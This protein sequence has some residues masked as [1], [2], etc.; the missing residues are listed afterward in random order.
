MYYRYAIVNYNLEKIIMKD[1][2][3]KHNGSNDGMNKFLV[4]MVL[5]FFAWVG[6]EFVIAVI[7][8]FTL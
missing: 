6:Y 8:R 5:L 4:A 7:E 3:W 2:S 1:E